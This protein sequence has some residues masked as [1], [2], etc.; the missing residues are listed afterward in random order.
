MG[1]GFSLYGKRE[2]WNGISWGMMD[3]IPV[4]WYA[5]RKN[6]RGYGLFSAGGVPGDFFSVAAGHR[7][8]AVSF[9]AAFPGVGGKL[10]DGE[11]HLHFPDS[12]PD[13]GGNL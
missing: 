7:A 1:Y 6:G 8:D 4:V 3:N 10:Y 11:F 9:R 13:F 12:F 2:D 5:Q